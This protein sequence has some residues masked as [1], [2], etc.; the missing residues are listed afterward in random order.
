MFGRVVS[1]L[2]VDETKPLT[3]RVAGAGPGGRPPK[4]YESN[5]I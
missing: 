4:T 5:F 3:L 2:N 1:G